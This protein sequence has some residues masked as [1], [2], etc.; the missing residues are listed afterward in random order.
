LE[1]AAAVIP[2]GALLTNSGDSVTTPSVVIEAILLA[3]NSVNSKLFAFPGRMIVGVEGVG[4]VVIASVV[5]VTRA[6]TDVKALVT[7][8]LPSGPAAIE[9]GAVTPL[10]SVINPLGVTRA[11][12]ST[13]CSVN[14]MF[15][16]EPVVMSPGKELGVGVRNSVNLPFESSKRQTA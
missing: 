11:N 9:P 5:G 15:P 4:N 13:A 14:H 8:R 6:I 1:A 3:L 10:N 12:L 7:Q 2:T 16:S